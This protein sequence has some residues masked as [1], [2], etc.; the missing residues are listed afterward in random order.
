MFTISTCFSPCSTRGRRQGQY[1]R[2]PT[3]DGDGCDY[4]QPGVEH[5]ENVSSN[6]FKRL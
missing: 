5:A 1:V 3:L 2:D 4:D 6:E